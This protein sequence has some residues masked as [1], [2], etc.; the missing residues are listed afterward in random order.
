MSQSHED[1]Q[2]EV[3]RLL[4]QIREEYEAAAQGLS[5]FAESAKHA[6]ITARMENMGKLQ[7]QVQT[8]VGE[9]VAIVLVAAHL[10]DCPDRTTI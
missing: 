6:F 8:L 1:A 10:E 5:G 3:G 9:E 4:D 7:Q 2:S